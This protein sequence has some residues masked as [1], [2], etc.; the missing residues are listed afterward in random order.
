[1]REH[2]RVTAVVGCIGIGLSLLVA[3]PAAADAAPLDAATSSGAATEAVEPVITESDFTVATPPAPQLRAA[4]PDEGQVQ[5]GDLSA[6]ADVDGFATVGVTWV[7]PAEPAGV[8]V[9]VRGQH[10]DGSWDEWTALEIEVG[11]EGGPAGT[12]PLVVGEV[13]RVEARM[14]GAEPGSIADLQLVVV[15]PGTRAADAGLP[16]PA[17]ASSPFGRGVGTL[18]GSG[19]L[20][21]AGGIVTGYPGSTSPP[22]MYSRAQW[23]ADESLRAWAPSQGDFKGAVIH[24]TAGTNS[25]VEADVPAILRGIY[26]YHAQTRG[27][28][29]IG[30]NFLVDKFGR[31]WEGRSGGFEMETA[32]AHVSGYNS[33]TVGVSVLGNYQTATVSNAAVDA[34]VRLLGWKLSI[35]GIDAAGRTV[36]NGNNLPTIFGHR[37]VASTT[38]PG[39][40]LWVRQDEIRRRVKAEQSKYAGLWGQATGNFVMSPYR[41]DVYL[42]VGGTKHHVSSFGILSALSNYGRV[43]DAADSYLNHLTTGK[44]LGRFVRDPGTGEI[45]FV[46][47]NVRRRAASCADIA[48][49]GSSCNAAVDVTGVQFRSL[50]AGSGLS[51]AVRA[52]NSDRVYYME[53]GRKRWVT[54]WARLVS[55]Y[56]GRAPSIT[57]LSPTAVSAFPNGSNI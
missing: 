18:P 26:A 5:A 2:W 10:A 56:G 32:G 55:L 38:C 39:Q 29:D 11:P 23:G 16:A 49:F 4:A 30:Y 45:A 14:R 31:I 44:P 7:G 6:V 1:M 54:S 33:A 40:S 34:I 3:P 20:E 13:Q 15:D 46:D 25:Y 53:N 19:S 51:R 50:S 17:P 47:G 41:S 28:G 12:A 8:D 57:V 36:I 9:S 24:H 42:V 35:H 43:S 22:Q 27:W 37:D 48:H 52:S 21:R